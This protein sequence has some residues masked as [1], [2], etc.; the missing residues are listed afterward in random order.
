MTLDDDLL[1]DEE[2]AVSSFEYLCFAAS[3]TKYLPT[4][5]MPSKAFYK[6]D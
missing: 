2:D 6:C 1:D 3:S 4:R 5:N